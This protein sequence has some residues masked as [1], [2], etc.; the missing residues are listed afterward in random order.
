MAKVLLKENPQSL[1]CGTAYDGRRRMEGCESDGSGD[2]GTPFR[3]LLWDI[4][5][6]Q[7]QQITFM[8]AWLKD[9]QRS[10]SSFET[11]V[12]EDVVQGD[13][14]EGNSSNL[15]S[16]VLFCATLLLLFFALMVHDAK[17]VFIL[18]KQIIFELICSDPILVIILLG[19][20][21]V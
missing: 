13:S 3:T 11:C 15:M 8:R 2:G 1:D 18:R 16:P 19:S 5:N 14:D 21:C 9:N 4:I 12:V 10:A 17:K 6:T 20:A 7:N